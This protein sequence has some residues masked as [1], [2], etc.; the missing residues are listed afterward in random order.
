MIPGLLKKQ[1]T[2]FINGKGFNVGNYMG[3][4]P[5]IERASSAAHPCDHRGKLV[6]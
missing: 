1:N 4:I 5:T 6:Y 2:I 3:D